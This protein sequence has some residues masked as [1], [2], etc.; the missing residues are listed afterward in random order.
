MAAAGIDLEK[1]RRV[2]GYPFR[3]PFYQ[4]M[5]Q[6]LVAQYMLEAKL[7]DR[8]DVVTI[9]F[10]RN[11]ALQC[12]SDEL[13]P[14]ASTSILDAWNSVITAVPCIRCIEADTIMAA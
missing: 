10:R 3:G 6:Y 8:A 12:V 5:R 4:L 11:T 7:T 9:H 1:A 14:L 13:K 2:T